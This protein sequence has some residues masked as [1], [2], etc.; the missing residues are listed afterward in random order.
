MN[1]FQ[2]H[3]FS[4]SSLTVIRM[5]A[6]TRFALPGAYRSVPAQ[7]AVGHQFESPPGLRRTTYRELT[8]RADSRARET[9]FSP[10]NA[11]ALSAFPFPRV[12]DVPSGTFQG[13]TGKNPASSTKVK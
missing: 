4:L 12:T 9:H 6:G 11:E 7:A 5:A 8:N 2:P 1:G 10:W 13:A 3:I